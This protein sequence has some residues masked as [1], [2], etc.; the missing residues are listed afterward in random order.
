MKKIYILT[1][2]VICLTL[3][4]CTQTNQTQNQNDQ[5]MV[6]YS[7]N[8]YK[9]TFKYPE[10]F[11]E[12]IEDNKSLKF[13]NSD[14]I[15]FTINTK[16]DVN[17]LEEKEAERL[18]NCS[19]EDCGPARGGFKLNSNLWENELEKIS[20][21]ISCDKYCNITETNNTKIL[22]TYYSE[23]P[24]VFHKRYTFYSGQYR[25]DISI[26]TEGM[27]N[28]LTKFQEMEKSNQIFLDLNQIVKTINLID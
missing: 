20:G 25:I 1:F 4:G 19:E 27:Y 16:E 5:G 24:G 3:T 23:W 2:L 10:K 14:K 6:L 7:S 18:A 28:D 21:K 15:V 11:V 8:K 26:L 17:I 13:S 12:V 9:F 22:V